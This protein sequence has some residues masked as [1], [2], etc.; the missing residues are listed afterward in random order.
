MTIKKRRT[1]QTKAGKPAPKKTTN[2]PARTIPVS[3][4]SR[5]GSPRSATPDSAI[6]ADTVSARSSKQT[7]ILNLLK[8]PQG[9]MIEDLTAAT[10]WQPHSVRGV[11]SGVLK[12]KLGLRITSQKIDGR[13]LYRV[14]VKP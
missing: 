3:R 5:G 13:R 7:A 2:Q 9:A 4:K 14:V 6:V 12:K 10:G 1:A 8:R 11:I